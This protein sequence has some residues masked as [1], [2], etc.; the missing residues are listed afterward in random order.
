MFDPVVIC[1]LLIGFGIVMY[2]VLDGFDL[3][4]GVLFPWAPTDDDRDVMMS[5][6]APVWDGNETW[7]IYGGGVLFAAFPLAYSIALPALYVPLMAM[8]VGLIFR[9]VAFEFR[10]KEKRFRQIWDYT[11]WA[12]SSLA[13]MAQGMMLGA[14]I[15]GFDVTGRQ[16]SGGPFDWL[17]SFSVTTGVGVLFGYGLLGA[18][19][20]NM[21]TRGATEVWARGVARPLALLVLLFIAMVSFKTPLAY[22]L[23]AE[24]W[25]SFPNILLLSPIP[26]ITAWVGVSL[27]RSLARGDVRAPFYYSV[28]LFLLSAAGL[29]ISL[30][31]NIAMPS[32][33]IWDAAAP[34]KSLHFV[35]VVA[36]FSVPII[37]GYTIFVYRIFR[38]KID[39][40][41][42]FY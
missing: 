27:L 6:I 38:G 40:D 11:F 25:F 37:I 5:S 23:I 2:G 8:L 14:M 34:P 18:T 28:G 17:T 33:T 3:G 13:A 7:L 10:L 19:W 39:S 30:W 4:V 22:P 15:E 24:R 36:M 31:P 16:F 35:L 21:K 41:Q 9:G 42:S 12:G 32:L 20:L 29:A 26:V 1:F